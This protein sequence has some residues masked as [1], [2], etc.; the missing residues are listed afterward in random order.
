MMECFRVLFWRLQ[1]FQSPGNH[2]GRYSIRNFEEMKF[3]K[4]DG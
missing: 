1:E 3:L 2:D 4:E